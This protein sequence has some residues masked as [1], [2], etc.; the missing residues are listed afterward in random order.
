LFSGEQTIQF[1]G[2]QTIQ[3]IDSTD[4]NKYNTNATIHIE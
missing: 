2:D 4:I 1:F 3:T